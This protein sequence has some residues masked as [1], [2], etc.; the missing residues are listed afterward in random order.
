MTSPHGNRTGFLETR[1]PSSHSDLLRKLSSTNSFPGFP[2]S[3]VGSVILQEGL[4]ILPSSTHS[5]L[6]WNCP[7]MIP[8]FNF[9]LQLL[10]A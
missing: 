5:N 8:H 1:W 2:A 9:V 4:Y 3:F 6:I 10:L 7:E